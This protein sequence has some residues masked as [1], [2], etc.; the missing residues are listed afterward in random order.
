VVGCV[1]MLY[2]PLLAIGRKGT[3]FLHLRLLSSNL[4]KTLGGPQ[5]PVGW[6]KAGVQFPHL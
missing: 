1:N 6:T 4:I 5:A 3:Q 2:P